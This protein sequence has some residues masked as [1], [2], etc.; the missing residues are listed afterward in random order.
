MKHKMKVV[1]AYMG[2]NN[3]ASVA[4]RSD[5]I[6]QDNRCRALMNKLIQ[7]EPNNGPKFQEQ[8]KNLRSIELQTQTKP[9]NANKEKAS[10]ITK[11]KSPSNKQTNPAAQTQTTP[12]NKKSPAKLNSRRSLIRPPSSKL[13][14]PNLELNWDKHER[15]HPQS[16]SPSIKWTGTTESVDPPKSNSSDQKQI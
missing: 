16:K 7:L 4:Q 11:V 5:I 10:E 2:K 6:N 13:D 9:V 15:P 8:L 14:N 3:Y 12:P 1:G